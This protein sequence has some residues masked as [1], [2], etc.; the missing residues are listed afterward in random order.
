MEKESM[1]IFADDVSEMNERVTELSQSHAI[2]WVLQDSGNFKLYS[3]V[4]R[5]H[6]DYFYP[7]V[8]SLFQGFCVITYLLF[9]NKRSDVK[10]LPHLIGCL[11]HTLEQELNQN[12]K[13]QKPLLDKYFNYRHK[14]FA[15]RDKS[16]SPAE[17]FGEQ[18]KIR[19]KSEMEAIVRLA[20]NSI[21][22]LA[23]AAGMDKVELAKEFSRREE[24][25]GRNILEIL[26]T[27]EKQRLGK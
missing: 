3:E 16:K 20:Q 9:D 12:I 5:F 8:S 21:C 19:V 11:N 18:K 4:F 17:L 6:R 25:A 13:N 10:S 23:D 2:L 7:T 22:S 1:T 24:H 15:H 26:Q 14:I 27:L